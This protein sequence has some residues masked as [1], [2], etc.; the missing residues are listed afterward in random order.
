MKFRS[1]RAV[2]GTGVP[3]EVFAGTLVSGRCEAVTGFG[4]LH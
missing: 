3:A 2:A 1:M 4:A